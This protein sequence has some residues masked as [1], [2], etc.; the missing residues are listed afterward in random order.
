MASLYIA[1][2]PIPNGVY[3]LQPIGTHNNV[4]AFKI[5]DST[6]MN[7]R[8]RTYRTDNPDVSVLV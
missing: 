5:G 8:R 1:I 4:F 3:N 6:D 7:G 2:T